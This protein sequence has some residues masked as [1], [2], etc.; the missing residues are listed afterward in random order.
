M[1]SLQG[2]KTASH[3]RWQTLLGGPGPNT[4]GPAKTLAGCRN[5]GCLWGSVLLL[6]IAEFGGYLRVEA[7]VQ[8]LRLTAVVSLYLAELHSGSPR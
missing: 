8:L 1:P 2:S 4:S 7:F 6:R 5:H 3:R